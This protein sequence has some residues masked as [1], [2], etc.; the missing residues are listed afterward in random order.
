[1]LSLLLVVFSFYY[2][3]KVVDIV[4]SK[5]PIMQTINEEK[6]KFEIA[7]VDAKVKSDSVVPG[8]NGKKV[9]VAKSF[10]K[11][12]QYGKYNESLYVFDEIEPSLSADNYYNKYIESGMD[13][14]NDVALVFEV[15]R[16]DNIDDVLTLLEDNDVKATFFMDGLFIENNRSL[17][18]EVS[19]NGYELELLNYNGGYDKIYFESSLHVLNSITNNKPKY[20]YSHY[21]RKEVLDICN[22]LSLH[23]VIPTINSKNSFNTVK[24]KLR[25]GAIIGLKNSRENL[26]TIINYIKQKGYNLVT[27]DELL[28]EQLEK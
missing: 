5:D 21:D 4:R 23:T 11:M 24:T 20:C 2:T 9:N 27:L 13:D 1:M 22:S 28:S 16:F 19:K 15:E 8:K 26:N 6:D 12:R 10:Q 17:L 3:N 7:A 25:G 18:E 14:E